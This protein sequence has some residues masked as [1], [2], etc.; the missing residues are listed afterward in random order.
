MS[1]EKITM[2]NIPDDEFFYGH[3]GCPGCGGSLAVRLALKVIG[4]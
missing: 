4:R 1:N 3:K 2:K